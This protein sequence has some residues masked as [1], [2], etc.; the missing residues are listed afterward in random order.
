MGYRPEVACRTFWEKITHKLEKFKSLE[1]DP[2]QTKRIA[3]RSDQYLTRVAGSDGTCPVDPVVGGR[4]TLGETLMPALM[5]AAEA[6]ALLPPTTAL[7]SSIFSSTI[8]FMI[9]FPW[10]GRRPPTPCRK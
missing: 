3:L 5:D 10:L 7:V 9:L 2:L 6:E 4:D 8:L 1:R